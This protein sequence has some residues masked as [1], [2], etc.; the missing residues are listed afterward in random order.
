VI[1]VLV[2][3]DH[4]VV[5]AGLRG[6]LARYPDIDVVGEASSATEA[7]A[8]ARAH[9]P[10]VVLMDLRLPGADG[11]QATRFVLAQ[12]PGCQVLILTTYD[13]NADIVR[14]VEAGAQGYLL[15]DATPEEL[16]HAVR[17]VAAGGSALSP[18]VAA[19]LVSRLRSPTALSAREIEVLRLVS[20]GH[21]NAEIGRALL[22]SQ[23]TVKTHLLRAFGKLGVSDRTAAVTTAYE[24][25]IL[26]APGQQPES[27]RS[28]AW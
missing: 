2:V 9:Q 26:P 24:L 25:G 8:A 28:Q 18:S 19:K 1:R 21:T 3:D 4:P 10:D 11:T 22:I 17:A 15:K 5:R 27:T 16:A 13:N 20:T 23:A 7:V 12:R 14:A 6:V